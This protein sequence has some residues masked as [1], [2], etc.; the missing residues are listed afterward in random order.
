MM[1]KILIIAAH[2]DDDILGCG[3]FMAK[4]RS[5]KKVKVIFL[6]EGTSCRY[7]SE[8]AKSQHVLEA[9]AARTAAAKKALS[10]L[11]VE[12]SSFYDFP[13]GQLDQ[14]PIINLNKI[15]EREIAS[16]KPDTILTHFSQD[17]NND[18]RIVFRSV[19]MAARPV[20]GV[21]TILSF[22]VPSSTEWS[23]N[24][25]FQPNYFEALTIGDLSSKWEALACYESE[26]RNYP[27]PRSREGIETL[28]KYRGVQVGVDYAEAFQV[29]RMVTP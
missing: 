1:N 24:V 7:P 20:V 15:I 10:L 22:E 26:I 9:I 23:L 13:C 3:G 5:N 14:L 18:H 28:A 27:H 6:A 8:E 25:S 16:F 19:S 11:G 2:P 4:Y 12:E 17:N 29:M 21:S